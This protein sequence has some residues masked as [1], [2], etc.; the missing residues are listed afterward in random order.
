MTIGT[1]G[2]WTRR[3]WL[4]SLPAALVSLAAPTSL[5]SLLSAAKLSPPFSTFVDIAPT[6]GLTHPYT[7]GE[8]AHVTYIIENMGPGCAFFDYD[9]DGWIDIFT[10][11]GRRLEGSPPGATNRLY[12]NN[13]NGTFTDVTEK[14]GLFDSGWANGVCVGDYDNDG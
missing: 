5:R 1:S 9:N 14:C 4:R 10:L 6:A 3:R 11:N 2:G 7:Y 13:R 12:K 8:P